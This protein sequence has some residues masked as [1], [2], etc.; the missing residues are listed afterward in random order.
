MGVEVADHEAAAVE[1][2][3]RR[4]RP[5]ARRSVDARVLLAVTA[6]LL[7][8]ILLLA[9]IPFTDSGLSAIRDR[10]TSTIPVGQTLGWIIDLIVA[11]VLIRRYRRRKSWLSDIF[12]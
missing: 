4:P 2:E 12:D 6:R 1:V 7:V 8:P 3:H 11:E 5:L 9:Q 10:V